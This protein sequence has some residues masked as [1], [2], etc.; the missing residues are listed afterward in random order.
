MSHEGTTLYGGADDRRYRPVMALAIS[1]E[2][3]PSITPPCFF[4]LGFLATTTPSMAKP[5]QGGDGEMLVIS[6]GDQT[7]PLPFDDGT[8]N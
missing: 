3:P 7:C 5:S 1:F 8:D 6:R 4:W 2:D